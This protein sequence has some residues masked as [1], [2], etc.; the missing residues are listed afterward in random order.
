[1]MNIWPCSGKLS[2]Q[3]K[4]ALAVNQGLIELYWEIGKMI[5]REQET[6][7]WGS[8]VVERLAVDLKLEFPDMGGFSRPQL[9][10]MRQFFIFYR[11]AD[12]KV[13]QVVRQIPWGRF[14]IVNTVIASILTTPKTHL[15]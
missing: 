2:T 5:V 8:A 4:A 11:E 7:G 9:F 15:C 1:M 14:S 10:F 13:L 6:K 3:I 12:E